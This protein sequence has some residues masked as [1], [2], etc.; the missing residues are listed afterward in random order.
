MPWV[1]RRLAGAGADSLDPKRPD[2]LPVD[3]GG[4]IR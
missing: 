3:P 1:R 2:L 4:L